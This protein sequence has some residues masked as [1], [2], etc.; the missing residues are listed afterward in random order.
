MEKRHL[1]KR[2]CRQVNGKVIC[3]YNEQYAERLEEISK[4]CSKNEFTAKEL[5]KAFDVD[6][7]GVITKADLK[8]L[9]KS[10]GEKS[11]ISRNDLKN[12]Y[13]GIGKK[14]CQGVC[15]IM[16]ERSGEEYITVDELLDTLDKNHDGKI[17]FGDFLRIAKKDGNLLFI[18]KEELESEFEGLWH[19]PEEKKNFFEKLFT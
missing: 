4:I 16:E 5:F 8:Q 3:N 17:L 2:E 19:S 18:T 7:D 12:L 6:G 13:S 9:A 11:C 1:P 14:I 15:Q 10:D